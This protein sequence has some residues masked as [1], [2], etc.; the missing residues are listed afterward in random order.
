[1][2]NKDSDLLVMA[3]V[4]AGMRDKITY[5]HRTGSN[6]TVSPPVTDTD[7]DFLAFVVPSLHNLTPAGDAVLSSYRTS[8]IPDINTPERIEFDKACL[9]TLVQELVDDGWTD[10]S[11][12]E[13]RH[14]YSSREGHAVRWAALRKGEYNILLTVDYGWF[15]AGA[16][17]AELCKS[18]NLTSKDDRVAIHREVHKDAWAEYLPTTR[19]EH[20]LSQYVRSQ[21]ALLKTPTNNT[22]AACPPSPILSSEQFV[23]AL[24]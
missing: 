18:L 13:Q 10:C 12:E 3:G 11:T 15:V 16:A 20:T 22:G 19:F 5:T 24:Q 4:N 21:L 9:A 6:Y 23:F 8:R 2:F 1:M 17:A 14:R 7:I